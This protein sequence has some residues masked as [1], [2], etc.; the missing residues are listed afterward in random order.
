MKL[1]ILSD[2]HGNRTH[3]R[4]ALELE[5]PQVVFHLG[6]G[7]ADI[8]AVMAD[9]PEVPLYS[10]PGNCDWRCRLAPVQQVTV[11]GLPILVAHGHTFGVKSG[12]QSYLAYGRRQGARLL[13]SGHTHVPCV[14]EDE[15]IMLVN[16]GSVGNGQHPTYAVLEVEQG[17]VKDC[18]IKQ[19]ADPVYEWQTI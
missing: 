2:S 11:E 1:L 7:R 15:G 6:D 13:L 14:W 10:V 16:P 4:R 3:L 17:T 18:Q 12:Y 5:K 8:L 9:L 19:I